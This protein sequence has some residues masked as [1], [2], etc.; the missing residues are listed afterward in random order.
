M[1]IPLAILNITPD[2]FSDGGIFFD[3]QSVLNRVNF[4]KNHGIHY[5]D[6]GGQ[7]TAPKNTDIGLSEELSRF[8]RIVSSSVLKEFEGHVLSIDTFRPEVISYISN[9]VSSRKTIKLVWNDVSGVVDD[10]VVEFLHQN[11]ENRYILCHNLCLKRENV[12]NHI[13]YAKEGNHDIVHDCISFFKN[14]LKLIPE[15]FHDQIILDSC[16]GFSKS[17]EQNLLLIKNHYLLERDLPFIKNWVVGV[18]RKSF[19]K[20]Y[21]EDFLGEPGIQFDTQNNYSLSIL[22]NFLIE[23]YFNNRDCNFFIRSHMPENLVLKH[24][25]DKILNTYD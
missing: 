4:L 24:N 3:E 14:A 25:F 18:S 12:C 2:S 8:D 11:K 10:S 23:K 19:L 7:S 17:R 1:H 5:F 22:E 16:F 21:L 13:N 20:K 15:Q 9:K 6:I